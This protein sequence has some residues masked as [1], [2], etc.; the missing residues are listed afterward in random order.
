MASYRV[1]AP[2]EYTPPRADAPRKP[3]PPG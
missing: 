2:K 3:V 1:A